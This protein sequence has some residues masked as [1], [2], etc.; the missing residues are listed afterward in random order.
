MFIEFL[1]IKNI[2]IVDQNSKNITKDNIN[3]INVNDLMEYK[4]VYNGEAKI[5]VNNFKS[6]ENLSIENLDE[7]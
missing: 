6:H 2:N 3:F 5:F 7:L 1:K 4:V